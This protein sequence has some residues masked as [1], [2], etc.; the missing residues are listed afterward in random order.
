MTKQNQ[1]TGKLQKPKADY[2]FLT[3]TGTKYK[4]GKGEVVVIAA[5]FTESDQVMVSSPPYAENN[6]G[7][8]L[9]EPSDMPIYQLAKSNNLDNR[10]RYLYSLLDD[11]GFRVYA[12]FIL[13]VVEDETFKAF[14]IYAG[15]A[16]QGN[17]L[18]DHQVRMFFEQVNIPQA[19]AK[20]ATTPNTNLNTNRK[21]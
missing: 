20:W 10:L 5:Y 11:F 21:A 16:G 13:G 12:L 8:T 9:T 18:P 7:I 4:P 14:D 6:L 17:F 19:E 2:K 15:V 1:P 3:E